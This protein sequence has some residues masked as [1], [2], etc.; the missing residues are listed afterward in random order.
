MDFFNAGGGGTSGNGATDPYAVIPQQ[1]GNGGQPPPQQPVFFQFDYQQDSGPDYETYQQQQQQQYRAS[2]A[3]QQSQSVYFQ[4]QMTPA[5]GSY[6]PIHSASD[7]DFLGPQTP[8]TGATAASGG[9]SAPYQNR[10]GSN[11][12]F[13]IQHQQRR[14]NQSGQQQGQQSQPNNQQQ[15]SQ[16]GRVQNQ[17]Q[18][19]QQTNQPSHFMQHQLHVAAQAQQMHHLHGAPIT[20]QQFMVPP[21]TM[22]QPQQIQQ[23]QQ[24]QVQQIHQMQLQQQQQHPQMMQQQAQQ[25]YHTHQQNQHQ[26]G[27]HQHQNNQNHSHTQNHPGPHHIPQNPMVG[28]AM[29]K[30]KDWPIRCVVEGKYHSVIYGPHGSTIKEISHS[31]HCRIEFPNLSKRERAA[32][33]NNDRILTVHGNAEQASKAVSRILHVI[34]SEALKDDN[35]VGVDIVLRLRAHNQ[36]CG[37]LIGKAGS[38]IKEIMQKREP[39][40]Q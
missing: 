16:S 3:S 18:M 2:Q 11:K 34:Q 33:G 30:L 9:A 7:H 13:L 15:Q 38:S 39:V 1:F 23:A 35:N 24:R 27:H 31:T 32:L 25:G 26:Q 6:F 12:E 20:P 22:M 29:F 4:N 37:R 21:P 8:A 40:L 19:Q 10:G 17:Q 36:L 28:R 5:Q 14:G